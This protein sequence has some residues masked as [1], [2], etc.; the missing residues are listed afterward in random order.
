MILCGTI[1]CF[2]VKKSDIRWMMN[3]EFCIDLSSCFVDKYHSL[4]GEKRKLSY[5]FR[6]K[7]CPDLQTLGTNQNETFFSA[8]FS[9]RFVELNRTSI[10]FSSV[11]KLHLLEGPFSS[12]KIS[13]D[14][15]KTARNH[16]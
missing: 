2:D 11:P 16:P 6:L 3:C 8:V 9:L 1:T 13:T 5:V 14:Y 12:A 10:D 4:K 15:I 7:N